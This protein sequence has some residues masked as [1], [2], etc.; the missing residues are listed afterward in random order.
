MEGFNFKMSFDH[1]KYF[2]YIF[3]L[4]FIFIGYFNQPL[5]DEP[6]LLKQNEDEYA[7]HVGNKLEEEMKIRNDSFSAKMVGWLLPQYLVSER[8]E[9]IMKY[10]VPKGASIGEITYKKDNGPP[11]A[12]LLKDN[13]VIGYIFETYDW[14]Q[15]TGY[16]RK[17]YHIITAIDLKGQ[18]IG[19]RLMWHTEPIAILGRTDDDL[20]DFLFQYPG[21]K[22]NKGI[23]LVLEMSGSVLGEGK[24][25]MRGTAGDT[26][27][28]Q[29]VDGIS[30]TT[31]TSILL[32]DSVMRASRKVARSR[33][34]SLSSQDLGIILN[35]EKFSKQSWPE[36]IS[37]GSVVK[38][39]I[40]NGD[41]MERFSL[42]GNI[43]A[44]RKAR[45][46]KEEDIWTTIYIAAVTP[47]GIGANIL[48]RR[49]YDQYVI[50]GR[51]VDDLVFWVAFEG[52]A[53]F[54]DKAS[55]LAKDIPFD[56]LKIKQNGTIYDLTPGMYKPL[57]FHHA[58]KGAPDMEAQGLFYF[59]KQISPN[60]TK[61]LE[62]QYIV[63]GDIGEEE[64]KLDKTNSIVFS[65]NYI[66]PESFINQ[67]VPINKEY[68]KDSRFN[69][70][71]TWRDKYVLVALSFITVLL[72]IILLASKDLISKNRILHKSIRIG[73][74]I[75]V[76]VWL[77][78]IAGGQ[79]SI[80]H[81]ASLIQG[82]IDRD[83]F[84]AFLAEP[85][86][87]IIGL[88]AV[89]FA[90]IWGRAL[91]CGWLCPFGA[92]QELLNKIAINLRIKQKHIS[93]NLDKKL[94]LGKYIVLMI[95]AGTFIYSFDLGLSA[96]SIEPFKTAITFRFNAPFLAISWVVTL[97][98]IGLFIERA[99]CRFLCPLGAAA[100]IIGKVRIFNFLHRHN[101]CGNPCKACVPVCPTQAVKPSGQIDMNECFQCLDCQVM[102]FDKKR[103]PPLVAKF[104]K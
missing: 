28:L 27:N 50:A 53:S 62:L 55:N 36:L 99:Y 77:G 21:K 79:V 64:V 42:L 19:A 70:Q 30:R 46:S 15:G 33:N 90:P 18:I 66:I 51:N 78:W 83:G 37:S 92:L 65:M 93:A 5:A 35:I 81:L 57:P 32:N 25:A 34:I 26:A 29:P 102:F 68:E 97:L 86:I 17:P 1:I 98:I 2:S 6:L 75:W 39:K 52:P 49:W 20:H 22:I 48:G 41:I 95:L 13:Q 11:S 24:V 84:A 54:Y 60:P 4:S 63:K 88:S 69:W 94:K 40:S 89:I 61:N 96:S 47:A 31:T 3:L 43:K 38:L 67:N 14:V 73:F 87:V 91:F 76:L 103:C 85:A 7:D 59:S 12:D 74:L 58:K 56:T 100:A 101:E 104:K 23:S 9:D 82:L 16:S 8:K 72:A 10:V 71:A 80:I 44:P 45:L